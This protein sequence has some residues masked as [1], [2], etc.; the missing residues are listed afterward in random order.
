MRVRTPNYTETNKNRVKENL[1]F[2]NLALKINNSDHAN[3]QA[4]Q[5]TMGSKNLFGR[6]SLWGPLK[7]LDRFAQ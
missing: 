1:H 3:F 4:R 2:I 6:N 7:R 5:F